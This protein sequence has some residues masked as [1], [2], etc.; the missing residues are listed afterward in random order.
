MRIRVGDVMVPISC[1]GKVC[2]SLQW[3]EGVWNRE[4]GHSDA[5]Q[6]DVC[7]V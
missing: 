1:G 5:L 2:E 6:C 7:F 4:C 3:E